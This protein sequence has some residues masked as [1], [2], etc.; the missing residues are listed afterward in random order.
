MEKTQD[1]TS[2]ISRFSTRIRT[3]VIVSKTVTL[4]METLLLI[5]ESILGNEVLTFIF[6][7]DDE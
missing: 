1:Y 2:R 5:R 4:W 6:S 7:S 3:S